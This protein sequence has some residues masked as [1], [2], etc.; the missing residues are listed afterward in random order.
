MAVPGSDWWRGAVIYEI[1]PRSFRD[2][3]GDGVG[4]LAGIAERLAHVADLGADAVWITP[5]YRS[6]MDDFGY[7]VAD[8]R[9]VDPVFGALADFEA[10][11]AEARRVGLKLLVDFVPSHTSS[12][13]AWFV[14]SRSSRHNPK[15][16]WYVWADRKADGTPP[17][18]WL[19]VFGGPAWQWDSRRRQYYLHNF[20]ASQPDLNLHNPE[21]QDA[22]LSEM[23]FWLDRGVAGFRLDALNFGMHDPQ[24]RDNPPA[25]DPSLSEHPLTNPYAY[26]RHLYDKS[27]PEM[28]AFLERIRALLD[29][30]GATT[31][32]AEIGD[33]S[34]VTLKLMGD[35]AGGGNRLH[36]AYGF[37][38]LG[39]RFSP[40]FVRDTLARH[41]EVA[42]DAWPC[43]AFS[44]HD[45]MR[46][47]SRWMRPGEDPAALA[48][49]AAGVLLS[50]RGSVCLYQGEELGLPEADVA[51]EDL[52]DPTGR[53]F[54]PDYKGRD[55]C[56]TP[57]PWD[58]AAPN[59]GFGGA[60]RPW[61]PVPP[62]HLPLAVSR[63]HG[64]P[65]SVLAFYRAALAARRLS[66]A[67]VAGAFEVLEAGDALLALRR[68][69]DGE[70][71]VCVFNFGEAP[72]ETSLVESG[73]VLLSTGGEGARLEPRGVRWMKVV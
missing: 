21:V 10:L 22:L 7:D 6:P 23:R 68:S 48:K 8:Y 29:G 13:H 34:L 58:D 11:A 45:C 42:G 31:S 28:P 37:E 71:I 46:H 67:L 19:S 3:N 9:E 12:A 60:G 38:F 73:D 65:G 57:M 33:D 32:L 61:L 24:L 40:R 69:V 2:T 36:M 15:A 16:D 51:F 27:R 17:N 47:V 63:Q 18:N 4:D 49:L 62:A 1:Y 55:G 59:A 50:L 66:P 20:L 54:W 72:V 64:D 39:S 53:T 26:Q 35:Y 44:N 52:Q 5:F 43:W 25:E 70:E 30:Y 41:A 56:R 14:E